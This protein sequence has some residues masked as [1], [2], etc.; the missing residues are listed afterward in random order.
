MQGVVFNAHWL[1]YFDESATR[2]FGHLGYEPQAAF[3][4]EFDVMVVR[5]TVEWQG[6]AGFDDPVEVAVDVARLGDRSF[7]LRFRAAVHGRDVCRAEVTYV[8]VPPGAAA[9]ERR[10]VPIPPGLRERLAGGLA[11]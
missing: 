3:A 4:E 9:G 5:A 1:T 8:S 11:G 6:P 10:S 7:D 2:F